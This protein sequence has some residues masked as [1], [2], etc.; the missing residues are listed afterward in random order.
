MSD[1]DARIMLRLSSSDLAAIDAE[2][3]ERGRSE[4]IRNAVHVALGGPDLPKP[5]VK[6]AFE[7]PPERSKKVARRVGPHPDDEVF[8]TQVRKMSRPTFREVKASLGWLGLRAENAERRLLSSGAL[9]VEAG[10]LVESA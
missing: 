5:E 9:R 4:F 8:L 3:G 10:A 1:L 6:P 7:A 2:V